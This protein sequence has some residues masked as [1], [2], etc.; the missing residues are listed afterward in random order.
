MLLTANMQQYFEKENIVNKSSN[1][2][3]VRRRK[4]P[5]E[6]ILQNVNETIKIKI[7]QFNKLV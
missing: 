2:L 4:K 3:F 7:K 5:F 1:Q 6:S